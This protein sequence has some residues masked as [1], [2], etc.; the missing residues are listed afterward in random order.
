VCP[1][2]CSGARARTLSRV[3]AVSRA[4]PTPH[5]LRPQHTT[6]RHRLCVF[7]SSPCQTGNQRRSGSNWSGAPS[8]STQHK[9]VWRGH[10]GTGERGRIGPFHAATTPSLAVCSLIE[11][12]T[13]TP[14]CTCVS[15]ATAQPTE[16]S[17]RQGIHE[18][19]H[20]S[21]TL[22]DVDVLGLAGTDASASL[23]PVVCRGV[24]RL[25]NQIC[26]SRAEQPSLRGD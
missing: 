25:Y 8:T 6:S 13:S 14:T 9:A 7:V 12:C 3:R 23:P 1:L 5:G 19:H 20:C 2:R 10:T 16:A 18:T 4:P 17:V 22:M 21:R 24:A 11:R 15:L 26:P